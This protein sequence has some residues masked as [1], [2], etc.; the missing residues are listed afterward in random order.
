MFARCNETKTQEIT[1]SPS[2][3][4]KSQ[5][6]SCNKRLCSPVLP[7]PPPN[8]AIATVTNGSCQG[9]GNARPDQVIEV[10]PRGRCGVFRAKFSLTWPTVFPPSNQSTSSVFAPPH[11]H[12]SSFEAFCSFPPSPSQEK[13]P[14]SNAAGCKQD[15]CI[16]PL[17]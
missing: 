3:S 7:E 17:P 15:T 16:P 9:D 10:N 12:I 2:R 13:T 5:F 14:G 6:C 1:G 11:T 4:L 8:E